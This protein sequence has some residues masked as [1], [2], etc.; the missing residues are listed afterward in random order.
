M[1][2]EFLLLTFIPFAKL[3]KVIVEH[4]VESFRK[5]HEVILE[6][7]PIVCTLFEQPFTFAMTDFT[8]ESL[9]FPVRI[10][11]TSLIYAFCLSPISFSFPFL[12]LSS[13]ETSSSLLCSAG[14]LWALVLELRDDFDG[15]ISDVV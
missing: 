6:V 7:G 9:R 11:L 15:D 4:C 10:L 12:K 14:S 8:H 1:E 2:A 3:W 5:A 13:R